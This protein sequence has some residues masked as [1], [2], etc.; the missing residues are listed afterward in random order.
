MSHVDEGTL[1]AYLDGEL[2]SDERTALEGHLGQCAICRATLAEERALL[3]RASALLG[4]ARPV[5]RAAPPFEQ[6]RRKPTRSPWQVRMPF[7]WAAS[8]AVALGIGYFFRNPEQRAP[9]VAAAPPAGPVAVMPYSDSA[10]PA[11]EENAVVVRQRQSLAPRFAA[12][13]GDKAVRSEL[14]ARADSYGAR[15]SRI[16]DEGALAMKSPQL[17]NATPAAAE[18]APS[19]AIIL[20]TLP[21]SDVRGTPSRSLYGWNAPVT[22]QWPV[23]SR[24]AAAS[25]LGADPVGLPGLSTRRIQ[26]SPGDGTVVVEQTL[27]SSTVIQIFQRPAI[28]LDSFDSSA[29]AGARIFRERDRAARTAAPARADRL[30][31]FVGRL[32]VEISGPLSSDSLNRLLEQVEPL[33]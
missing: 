8:I 11:Q 5:E 19:A 22:T 28:A 29:E 12:P 31:R 1:H 15:Q 32:R 3:E 25:L 16:A 14:Q 26:R 4:S 20:E 24:G 10:A 18:P 6:L 33:P 23:I 17:R 30:A 21:P 9:S 13:A 2:P 7:A 27:D